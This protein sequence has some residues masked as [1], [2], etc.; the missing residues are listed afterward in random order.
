[1]IRAFNEDQ[2]YDQF[3][4]EQIAGDS[5]GQGD[6]TGYLVAG[7]HVPVA[8]VGQEPSARRQARADRMDEILQTV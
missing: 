5:V 7:P 8:T 4:F 1:M 2:P 3:L 6:A